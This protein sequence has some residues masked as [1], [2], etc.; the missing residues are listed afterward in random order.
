MVWLEDLPDDWWKT[1]QSNELSSECIQELNI[2]LLFLVR[3]LLLEART[4]ARVCKRVRLSA[5]DFR[6]ALTARNI[7]SPGNFTNNIQHS[8]GAYIS[9]SSIIEQND[10]CS[11][12]IDAIQLTIHWLAIDGQQPITPENSLPNFSEENSSN[13]HFRE[14]NEKRH[15]Q[16]D[17]QSPVLQQLFQLANTAKS[18]Y[19][20]YRHSPIENN[21]HPFTKNNLTLKPIHPR[22][23]PSRRPHTNDNLSLTLSSNLPHEL[24]IEQ[25]LYFK[26]LTE[27]CFYGIDQQRIDAFHCLAS[28]AALQPLLPRL[29]LFISKGIQTNIY[30]NDLNFILQFLSIL[31]IL[32]TNAFISFA[33]HLHFIIPS[34]LTCLLCLFEPTKSNQYL[35][36][37]DL[38]QINNYSTI[39]IMRETASDLLSYFERK[40]S[41][42]PYLTQRICSTIQSNLS[43]NSSNM[44]YSIVYASIRTLLAIDTDQYRSFIIDLLR[45]KV[46]AIDFDLD[47]G[48]QQ[49]SFDQ[50]IKD[51][52][53]Y[54]DQKSDLQ[55]S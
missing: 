9:L 15:H 44:T 22:N 6:N 52:L 40:Y 35:S 38:V 43:N 41:T 34:L 31:K 24:S 49:I 2:E 29:L 50:K 25:Q 46:L 37:L 20:L 8:E 28:D 18:Q 51:L 47:P 4:Y 5:N 48:E 10:S 30:L 54:G 12:D 32:T 23:I 11:L 33:K 13:I 16:L 17:D 19:S 27:S 21:V 26:S 1:Y 42:I 53:D 14:V 3:S 7:S 39:W 45:D 36:S 55:S